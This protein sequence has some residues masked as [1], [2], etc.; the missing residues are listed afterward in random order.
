YSY[1]GYYNV[2]NIG[3]EVREPGK[4]IP[5]SIRRSVLIVI[6]LFVAIHLAMLGVVSWHDIT[7]KQPD[8]DNFSLPAEFMKRIYGADSLAPTLMTVL[9][10]W[11]IFG[12]AFAGLLGY[13]R[14]PYGAARN[15]HFFSVFNAVH[16][17]LQIPHRSLLLIGA[18][19]LF[20]T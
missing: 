5:Q 8:L 20:W 11:C 4:A 7:T 19:M 15:G 18:M 3:D 12:S 17:R 10:I 1:L 2:C 14:I 16:P 13:S 9:L 6:I